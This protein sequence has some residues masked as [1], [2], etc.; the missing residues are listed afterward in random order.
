MGI[1]TTTARRKQRLAQ[2]ASSVVPWSS[3]VI[4]W[5]TRRSAES[6]WRGG[7]RA[8]RHC[9]RQRCCIQRDEQHANVQRQKRHVKRQR[10]LRLSAAVGGKHLFFL[11]A[12]GLAEQQR[13]QLVRVRFLCQ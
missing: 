7:C 8:H 4:T 1:T 11:A 3:W 5:R 13:R 9:D 10:F 12:L 2:K 6:T